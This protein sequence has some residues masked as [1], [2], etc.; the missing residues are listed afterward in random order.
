MFYPAWDNGPNPAYQ[1]GW[2][3]RVAW[4][5]VT[6]SSTPDY[7]IGFLQ[8]ND[9]AGYGCDGSSG[10]PPIWTFTGSLG[11]LILDNASQYAKLQQDV[12]G[13]PQSAPFDGDKMY[14]NSAVISVI[15]PGSTSN[16][17][18]LGNPQGDGSAGA[19][20]LV[21]FDPNGA[22]NASNNSLRASNLITG[23]T[24]HSAGPN[25]PLATTGPAF[26]TYNVWNLFTS[27]KRPSC[28]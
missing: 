4:T 20:W 25:Q 24:S 10:T 16:I 19:P 23:L 13:Y 14:Q 27:T 9:L 5:W 21:G 1:N 26:L 15:N 22:P 11:V 2:T 8:L 7:D 12:L 6:N 18:E 17:V 28:Q 3:V